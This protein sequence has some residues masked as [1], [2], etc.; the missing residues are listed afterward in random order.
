MIINNLVNKPINLLFFNLI[1]VVVWFGRSLYT[2][3]PIGPYSIDFYC[4]FQ[5]MRKPFLVVC[6][7]RILPKHNR[8]WLLKS[9]QEFQINCLM[10]LLKNFVKYE[11]YGAGKK[12]LIHLMI[13]WKTCSL[14]SSIWL[15]SSYHSIFW[16][17]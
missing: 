15:L 16:Q 7:V 8:L 4:Y 2:Y 13:F 17:L 12:G 3:I 11:F 10:Y 14:T 1:F 9:L 5:E 6:A